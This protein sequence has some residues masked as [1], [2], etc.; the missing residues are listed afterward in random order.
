VSDSPRPTWRLLVVSTVLAL[1]AAAGTVLLLSDDAD[2][3]TDDGSS[4]VTLVPAEDVPTFDEAVYTT[5]SGDEVPLSSVRGTPT[6]VNFW[7]SYCTPC[8]QEMPAFEE[9]YREVGG[10]EVAFLGLAVADRT[11]DAQEMADKTGVTYPLGQDKDASVITVLEGTVLPTT[12]LLDADG[13]VLSRHA[14]QM[15]ADDL[16]GLLADE[17]GI[18]T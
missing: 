4:P 3:G 2:T 9:V 18:K 6:V 13:K 17:L 12:V 10:E 14:G 5:F 11:D 16:R 7:A 1:I 8:L 15:S